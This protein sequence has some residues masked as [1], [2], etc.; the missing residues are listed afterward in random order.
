MFFFPPLVP[1]VSQVSQVDLYLPAPTS[2]REVIRAYYPERKG[3]DNKKRC[4]P[5]FLF[6]EKACTNCY[7]VFPYFPH[8][9]GRRT[10]KCQKDTYINT[11]DICRANCRRSHNNPDTKVGELKVAY[12]AARTA[13]IGQPCA[14]CAQLLDASFHFDHITPETKSFACSQWR[15]TSGMTLPRLEAELAKCQPLCVPCHTKKTA[16]EVAGGV[17]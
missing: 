17:Y 4:L 6:G 8:F 16:A 11:C 2:L 1:Q 3:D 15:C 7:R 13:Q 12:E 14:G 9:K 10:K 5:P